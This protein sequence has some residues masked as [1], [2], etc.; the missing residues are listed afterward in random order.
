MNIRLVAYMLI[1]ASQNKCRHWSR[2][3]K[4]ICVQCRQRQC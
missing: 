4:R 2:R 1:Q 3:E